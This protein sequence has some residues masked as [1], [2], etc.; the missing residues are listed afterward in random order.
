M[1]NLLKI[2]AQESV[3][4]SLNCTSDA[5]LIPSPCHHIIQENYDDFFFNLLVL[6]NLHK[7]HHKSYCAKN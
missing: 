2:T 5:L 6:G 7:Y 3:A 4:R 1:N